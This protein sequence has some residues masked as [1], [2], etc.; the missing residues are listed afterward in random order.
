M[1]PALPNGCRRPDDCLCGRAELVQA[2]RAD[3]VDYCF[4]AGTRPGRLGSRTLAFNGIRE[5]G[6]LG[7]HDFFGDIPIAPDQAPELS[8]RG[9]G[10]GA[11]ELLCICS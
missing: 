1:L 8:S 7:A 6:R 2:T 9:A 11:A 4:R 5:P 3:R 10:A